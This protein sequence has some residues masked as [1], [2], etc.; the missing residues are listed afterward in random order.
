MSEDGPEIIGREILR[1]DA[2]VA[3]DGATMGKSRRQEVATRRKALVWALN[4]TLT[5]DRTKTPGAEVEAFLGAL[6]AR[7]GGTQ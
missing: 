2:E 3:R 1:L 6:Q 4:A 7:E 5:G